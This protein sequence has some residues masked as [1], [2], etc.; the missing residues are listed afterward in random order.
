M[1]RTSKGAL[2]GTLRKTCMLNSKKGFN[3]G[4]SISK[5]FQTTTRNYYDDKKI[6]FTKDE[7]EE[8]SMPIIDR[9][10][11]V[12]EAIP[13]VMK[14]VSLKKTR[15]LLEL[16]ET[17]TSTPEE[18]LNRMKHKKTKESPVPQEGVTGKK[19]KG[20]EADD[21]VYNLA[22]DKYIKTATLQQ[23]AEVV[24]PLPETVR[25][26]SEEI[27]EAEKKKRLLDKKPQETVL[28]FI[29]QNKKK[30][31]EVIEQ[32]EADKRKNLAKQ[33]KLR[34][35]SSVANTFN[36]QEDE[37]LDIEGKTES[38]ALKVDLE[39]RMSA[40]QTA[41]SETSATVDATKAPATPY[42]FVG[43]EY[44]NA[45]ETAPF[46]NQKNPLSNLMATREK[47]YLLNNEHLDSALDSVKKLLE[48]TP[49]EIEKEAPYILNDPK[50][51][52]IEELRTLTM[53]DSD[54]PET[55]Q[56]FDP[57]DVRTRN[58]IFRGRVMDEQ[59]LR[60]IYTNLGSKDFDNYQEFFENIKEAT[61]EEGLMVRLE[62][63]L[64]SIP[65]DTLRNYVKRL[66]S[67]VQPKYDKYNSPA[68]RSI[69]LLTDEVTETAK[70]LIYTLSD[71]AAKPKPRL[72][73]VLW[74]INQI[75]KRQVKEREVEMVHERAKNLRKEDF[76]S[77]MDHIYE[78]LRPIHDESMRTTEEDFGKK[79]FHPAIYG[80]NVVA[81]GKRKSSIANAKISPGTGVFMINKISYLDYFQLPRYHYKLLLPFKF[82]NTLNQF[83]VDVRV[84]GGGNSGQCDAIFLALSK[85]LSKFVPEF[86]PVLDNAG[87]LY[88]DPRV[89]ERKKFGQKKARKKFTFVK[90]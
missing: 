84:K 81:T 57:N 68:Q 80:G 1:L 78:V 51:E 45:M 62:E 15:G 27:V 12:E 47:R 90:R 56:N 55:Y 61:N 36:P 28:Q 86:G 52:T 79:Q 25:I 2:L 76:A 37:R 42:G 26:H 8:G 49:E 34:Y 4:G 30:I 48:K 44:Y 6:D 10:L 53:I 43:Q 82:T 20:K 13:I 39:Q 88:R 74:S 35:M 60:N 7:K 77:P 87:F 21:S 89:V 3:C 83:D 72:Y 63:I 22:S 18:I 50:W 70:P 40:V 71:L 65:K 58:N 17:K 24:N 14:N 66:I 85:A 46:L 54:N 19:K 67:F 75:A 41:L 9:H 64:P 69:Q 29:N 23:I 16:F 5:Q 31:S 33:L 38:E 11:E 32:D 59:I 73:T